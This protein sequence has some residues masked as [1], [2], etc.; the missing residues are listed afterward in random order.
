M[1]QD[2][3]RVRQQDGDEIVSVDLCRSGV[4]RL[5]ECGSAAIPAGIDPTRDGDFAPLFAHKIQFVQSP[6]T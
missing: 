3:V 1:P 5:P 2:Q 4:H 6:P